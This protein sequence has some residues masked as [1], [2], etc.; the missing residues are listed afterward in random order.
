MHLTNYFGEV[1][2]LCLNGLQERKMAI[3]RLNRVLSTTFSF[4]IRIFQN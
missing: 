2:S 3:C 4:I 1:S